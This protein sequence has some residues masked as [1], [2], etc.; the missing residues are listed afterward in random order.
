MVQAD[1]SEV[2][3]TDQFIAA[4]RWIPRSRAYVA[5][6]VAAWTGDTWGLRACAWAGMDTERNFDPGELWGGQAE[7]FVSL[8]D[9][10]KLLTRFE[11]VSEQLEQDAGEGW[12]LTL[13]LNWNL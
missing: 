3:A 5:G 2:D 4:T 10:W 12:T 11:Y 8:K 9:R 6:P 13:G 1:L 7:I